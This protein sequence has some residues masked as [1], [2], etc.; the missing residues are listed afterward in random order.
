[1]AEYYSSSGLVTTAFF[2]EKGTE[3]GVLRKEVPGP[4]GGKL[5]RLLRYHVRRWSG[6]LPQGG[7]S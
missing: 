2:W 3:R 1:M 7:R 4:A 5:V 6:D